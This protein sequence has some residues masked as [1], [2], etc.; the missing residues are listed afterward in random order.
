MILLL[1]T[2]A[3]L[4]AWAEP[5]K[6]SGRLEG[7]LQDPHNQ[8]WVSAASAWEIATKHRIGK[9]PPAAPSLRSG[10]TGSLATGSASS[11]CPAPMHCEP[12]PCPAT[13]AIPSTA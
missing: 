12:V 13:T 1:D 8:V 7:L 6:L 11:T 9:Y 4:W 2:C 3:L 5:K 10:A